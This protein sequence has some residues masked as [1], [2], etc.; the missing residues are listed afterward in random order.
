MNKLVFNRREDDFIS[1][2]SRFAFLMKMLQRSTILFCENVVRQKIN[3]VYKIYDYDTSWWFFK[4]F[5]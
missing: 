4:N 1:T 2:I 3:V 5:Q